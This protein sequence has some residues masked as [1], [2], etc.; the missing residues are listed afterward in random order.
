[1][2]IFRC[3]LSNC[4]QLKKWINW[5]EKYKKSTQ[6]KQAKVVKPYKS[7]L[8]TYKNIIQPFKAHKN[9]YPIFLN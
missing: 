7:I 3:K 1:V 5:R 4:L 9:G 8:S 6:D 2:E